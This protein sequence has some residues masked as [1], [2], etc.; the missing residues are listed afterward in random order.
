MTIPVDLILEL[1]SADGTS[2]EFYQTGEEGIKDTLQLLAAPRLLSQPQLVLASEE[3]ASVIS[4]R[5]IDVIL[6]RTSVQP[7]P[8]FP[9]NLAACQLDIL[10]V[11]QD[12]RENGF[13]VANEPQAGNSG[14]LSTITTHVEIHTI[15]GWVVT[16]KTIVTARGNALDERQFF[17]HLLQVPVIPFRLEQGGIG[18][19]NPCNITRMSGW[20]KPDRLP[21]TALPLAFSRWTPSPSKT[22]A[23]VA[24]PFK[25]EYEN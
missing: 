21:D 19:I 13:D 22:A 12:W 20:P 16:V 25:H 4:C 9:L 1:R 3:S 7:P 18:F 17:G 11:P 6:A 23:E 8:I 10:E 14:P 15:G 24:A 2:T 5:G